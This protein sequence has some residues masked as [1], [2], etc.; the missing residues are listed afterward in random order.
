MIVQCKRQHRS[1]DFVAFLREVDKNGPAD[2]DNH[3]IV[4]NLSVHKSSVVK[5][6]LVRNP[7]FHLHFTPTHASWLKSR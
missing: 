7:R 3:V 4:D 6:W 2:L 1:T 5:R